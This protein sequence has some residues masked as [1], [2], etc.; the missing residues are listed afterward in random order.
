M[1][2]GLGTLDR[3]WFLEVC[4]TLIFVSP[5]VEALP[6]PQKSPSLNVVDIL[7]IPIPLESGMYVVTLTLGSGA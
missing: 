7:P 4:L 5:L 3:L 1:G 2:L 6:G